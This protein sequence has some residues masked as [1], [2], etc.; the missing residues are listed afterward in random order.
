VTM[1]VRGMRVFGM[2]EEHGVHTPKRTWM[3]KESVR[4]EK[5]THDSIKK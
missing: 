5:G 3:G 4:V 2:W 1:Y